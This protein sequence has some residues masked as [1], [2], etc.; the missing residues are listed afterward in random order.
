MIRNEI[1]GEKKYGIE[2]TGED[3]LKHL[4]KKGIDISHST[5]YM[6]AGYDMLEE[7][8]SQPLIKHCNHLLDIGCGKGR[9]LCVAAHFGFSHLEGLEFSKIF[10]KEAEANLEIIKQRIP[11]IKYNIVNNDAFY[12]EIPTSVDCIFMFNPFDE[13]IMSGV[14]NNIE[15]SLKKN[16]RNLSVVYMNPL[17]KKLFIDTGYN[18]IFHRRKLKYLEACILEKETSNTPI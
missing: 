6:P 13:I 2:T 7:L 12:F 10:C 17:H 4:D 8:F 3:E 5:I 15:L 14:I 16:P 9:V 11:S 18:E 1:K